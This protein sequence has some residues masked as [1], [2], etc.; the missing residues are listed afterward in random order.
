[1]SKINRRR[2]IAG[3]GSAGFGVHYAHATDNTN[4]HSDKN[5]SQAN[6]KFKHGIASGD[7]LQTQIILWTRLSVD[8]LAGDYVVEWQ[9]A[10][11]QSFN[12]IKSRGMVTTSAERDFTV[13]IDAKQLAPA[14]EYFYRFICNDVISPIG[15]SRTLPENGVEKAKLAVVSCSNYGYGYF[16]VYQELSQQN[17]LTA[18]LHLGDYIYEYPNDVYTSAELVA[19]DRSVLPNKEILA[20]QDYRQRYASYR[21]D[22]QLQS[23]HAAHPFICVWDDHELANNAWQDG[24]Q[25]HQ[26]DE[27]DWQLRREAAVQAYR[28]WLPIR[29]P[30]PTSDSDITYRRFDIGSLASLLMLDT[31]LIGRKREFSYIDDMIHQQIAF[32][33][34]PLDNGE[35]PVA[36]SEYSAET[37]ESI[38]KKHIKMLT[39]PFDTRQNPPLPMSDWEQVNALDPEN[40]PAGYQ[41][42]PDVERMKGEVINDP[43]RELLGSTQENWLTDN[44]IDSS[45]RDIPWQIIGQQVLM[46]KVCMPDVGDLLNHKQGIPKPTTDA[47]IGLGK[48][49]LPFNPDTWD[50]YNAN[51]QRVLQT[52]KQHANNAITLAGDTHNSWAFNLTP[53]NESTPVAVEM[54]TPSI[55][56]PGME[57]YLSNDD[58]IQFSKQFV[59]HNPE[60]IYHDSHQR[61][62]LELSLES[63]QSIGQWHYI[64]TVDSKEYRA[65]LGPSYRVKKG[66]H[67]LSKA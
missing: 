16:N 61:G 49:G 33:I 47:M 31:R 54:G 5:S 51:K 7:P 11:D 25:N 58:P 64:D 35:T 2:F 36:L 13:K 21:I 15:R 28:E 52:I 59:E 3:L 67:R 40:L 43:A 39:V 46:G 53:D 60:L 37:I 9:C 8:Q 17:D 32:N 23:A 63:E 29:D 27:G 42:L 34:R 50:G 57:Q 20:L 62:W 44:L 56:S 6:V 26:D 30:E 14:T 38:D 18:I 48:L 65:F 22:P 19:K 24:A 10:T 55:S 4:S 41:F 66:D 45:K 12:E 1:M